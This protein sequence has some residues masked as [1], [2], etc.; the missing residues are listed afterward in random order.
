[1]KMSEEDVI[2]EDTI[3]GQEYFVIN[4]HRVLKS[5]I[6]N[7][8]IASSGSVN[9]NP[10]NTKSPAFATISN[11]TSLQDSYHKFYY[12]PGVTTTT[13]LTVGDTKM[14][15]QTERISVKSN[16]PK[17]EKVLKEMMDIVLDR[18]KS[19]GVRSQAD[20]NDD[21]ANFI[22]KQASRLEYDDPVRKKIDT[23]DWSDI[24]DKIKEIRAADKQQPLTPESFA[25][26]Q[27]KTAAIASVG[28]LVIITILRSINW[29]K[30][31]TSLM[32]KI[33]MNSNAKEFLTDGAQSNIQ[34]M[35]A[36]L[37]KT[38]K[39]TSLVNDED[40]KIQAL[41]EAG[42]DVEAIA[43]NFLSNANPEDLMRIVSGQFD[44]A[45]LGDRMVEAPEESCGIS[46]GS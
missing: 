38:A 27:I 10:N 30:V 26:G 3:N 44:A 42:I 37:T 21:L 39:T 6:V 28:T 34:Q 4:G 1:M 11:S 22:S 33:L 35:I 15:S 29:D 9:M 17:T 8:N 36:D 32:N 45:D 43:E 14:D 18:V 46:V 2:Y 7:F 31:L 20:I 24:P 40:P 23:T 19:K 41:K 25:K 12:T 5:K 13:T 16:S